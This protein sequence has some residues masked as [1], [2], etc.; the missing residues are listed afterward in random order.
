M[1]DTDDDG[2]STVTPEEWVD[3]FLALPRHEQVT[4]ARDMLGNIDA[5]YIELKRQYDQITA[6]MS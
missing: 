5:I 1:S 4:F 3:S 2:L 6:E